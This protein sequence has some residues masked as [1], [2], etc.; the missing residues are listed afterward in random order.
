MSDIGKI[1]PRE[2][3]EE[4]KESYLDYAMSVIV[5]RALPDV[6]DGLKPVHRRILYTMYGLGL[7]H[8]AKFR[9]SAAVVG[10]TLGK[11]H[12]HG[13]MAVY[14]ALARMAQDFSLRYPLIDGQGNWG[15]IDGDSQA[16]MRYTEAKM[17]RIAEEMLKDIEKET[18]DWVPNY[19]GTK[20]E[21]VVLPAKVPQLVLNG[22][23]GIAVG[24][25]TNI[26]PHNLQE[27]CEAV[28]HLVDHPKSTTQDLFA[29]IKG[30]DFP[31]G[32]QIYNKKEIVEAYSQGRG[33]FVI[34]G[35]AEIVENEKSKHAPRQII[36]HE[37]PYQVNKS[38][39]IEKM[40]ELV[41][42]KKVDGV[43]DIRDESDKDGLR[44]AVDLRRESQPQKTLN[45]FYK[46]TDL[47]KSFHINMLALVDGIQP[48]VLSLKDVL[49]LWLEHRYV[50]VKRRAQYDL[51]R[52]KERSHILEG[53]K[54]ALE[55]IDAIIKTIKSS[56]DKEAAHE[57]LMKKF[58]FSE[59]Q[60][61][62]IL[63]M[64]LQTLAGLERQ[65][66]GEEL[67]DKRKL[68]R[69][70]T[71]LLKSPKKIK[72]VVKKE[73]QEIKD[74]Y[75]DERK[76]KVFSGKVGDFSEEDLI[77]QE[78]TILTITASG[79]IKR[80]NPSLYKIQLRGGKGII[81][82]STKGE[83]IVQHFLNAFTHD[84]VLF[85]TSRG[86]VFKIPV[87]E[88]PEGSRI[89]RGRA[90]ANFLDLEAEEQVTALITFGKDE[91]H[92][93]LVMVTE[94][95][96]IKKVQ[97][98]QFDVVRRNGLLAIRLAKG[99]ILG[100][101]RKSTGKDDIIL[102]SSRGQAIRF[103]ESD[104]RSMGR[105]AS[106]IRGMR[107]A[108][109]DT[110]VGVEVV[111]DN[112]EKKSKI[113]H[114]AGRQPTTDNKRKPTSNV[115]ILLVVMELGFGKRTE[116]KKFKVQKRGGRGIK[117]AKITSKNGFIVSSKVITSEE[118]LIV[119]SQKGQVIRINLSQVPSQGRTTQ[120]VKVMR[121]GEGDKVASITCL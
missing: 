114:G 54:K 32:G 44:I 86:R 97:K 111:T 101:V 73:I 93:Y 33:S 31:T 4:M 40:A 92:T 67:K 79:Y 108:K 110:I 15:S 60:A 69:E 116:L 103:K 23:L 2:I 64:R 49:I 85:F 88:V 48:R 117:A 10:D 102:V 51:R 22:T 28:I 68:I 59:I 65:K 121:L 29:F 9:K 30:P 7:D 41:R 100:W 95:G 5:S 45:T 80:T 3:T 42:N 50:V 105:Q 87:Y 83:D 25:A 91:R 62:A 14:D 74:L 34:R 35:R 43:R 78:E 84:N 77:P 53:L 26:P 27:V 82:L 8:S 70:L 90:L 98:E 56:P 96:V 104:V 66:I 58:T 36:I 81:G 107:L 20:K 6:R 71:L 52:A 61:Q 13:D 38:L 115:P 120:G 119:I 19:D 39:L 18:V 63:D 11:Y 106:G 55:R 99:D 17:M 24:M 75:G 46:F 21:P 72:R 1:E 118:E 76:T 94:Q 47:Q 57:R 109:D 12:P 16:A 89:S 112:P 113:S 37:I